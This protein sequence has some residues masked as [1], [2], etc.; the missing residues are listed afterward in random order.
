VGVAP[1]IPAFREGFFPVIVTELLAV[2]VS[3]LNDHF[4]VFL[5][6]SFVHLDNKYFLAVVKAEDD[7]SEATTRLKVKATID[8]TY[9]D[10]ERLAHLYAEQ[11]KQDAQRSRY[12]AD[13]LLHSPIGLP[14][15]RYRRCVKL[16]FS[17]L[18]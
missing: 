9:C 15:M 5:W 3:I 14:T 2:K 11:R 7:R 16:S 4:E 6:T 10:T 8:L 12:G 1:K 18:C 13:Q 17:C